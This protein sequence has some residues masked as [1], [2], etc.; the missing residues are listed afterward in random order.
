MLEGKA[1]TQ[2]IGR[3]LRA[4]RQRQQLSLSELAARTAGKLSKPRISS[5]EQGRRRM[6]L[7]QAV[8]LAEALGTVTPGDLLCL[9]G[10]ASYSGDE[11]TLVMNYRL[12]SA[13]GQAALM[14][15]SQAQVDASHQ[16]EQQRV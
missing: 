4:E 2:E 6:G 14:A 5:Y 3:R 16:P 10:R 15:F 13:H 8:T 12:A 1:L 7:E 9:D 11:R